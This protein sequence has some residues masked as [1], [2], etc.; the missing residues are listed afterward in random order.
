MTK[1]FQ[2]AKVPIYGTLV[3]RYRKAHPSFF[4]VLFFGNNFVTNIFFPQ[5][6]AMLNLE[7]EPRNNHENVNRK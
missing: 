5:M 6:V 7:A 1:S 3:V 2:R 4:D